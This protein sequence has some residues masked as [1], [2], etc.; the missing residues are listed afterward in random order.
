[1][2]RWT[3]SPFTLAKWPAGKQSFTTTGPQAD[4]KCHLQ[5][6]S[7]SEGNLSFISI[8]R[9]KEHWPRPGGPGWS[10]EIPVDL[11]APNT[12]T[13]D[14][15]IHP[16]VKYSIIPPPRRKVRKYQMEYAFL[17]K[18]GRVT[19]YIYIT[20]QCQSQLS[21]EAN[22]Q[23]CSQMSKNKREK[24]GAL[25]S[26]SSVVTGNQASNVE[27]IMQLL[28]WGRQSLSWGSKKPKC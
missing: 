6:W 24:P 15:T 18:M 22:L 8:K 9:S 16:C 3:I 13:Y 11:W 26:V 21:W 17:S 25:F 20:P 2:R 4:Y 12:F 7:P 23:D 19:G 5:R 1:M 27:E 10:L 28:E 14:I